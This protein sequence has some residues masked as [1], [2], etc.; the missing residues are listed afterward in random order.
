MIGPARPQGRVRSR[1]SV[2]LAAGFVLLALAPLPSCRTTPTDGFVLNVPASVASRV[3]WYEV[4]VFP[5]PGCTALAPQLAGG[6]PAEGYVQRLA[7]PASDT[8]PPSIADLPRAKYAIG[9]AARASDCSVLATGCTDADLSQTSAV[10]VVLNAVPTP[11]GAC[12]DGATCADAE[13]T[14]EGGDVGA[15]C[16]LTLVGAGPLADPL[17]LLGTVMSAPALAATGNGF[18]IAYREWDPNTGDARITVIPVDDQGGL[19]TPQQTPQVPCLAIQVSDAAALVFSGSSG[20]VAASRAGC[21]SAMG[22]ADSGIDLALVDPNG[23]F[24]SPAFADLGQTP[25]QLSTAHAMAQ[26]GAGTFVAYVQG[27]V[28]SVATLTGTSLGS[29]ASFGDG[30]MADG[31][32]AASD[33][34][35]ALLGRSEPASGSPPSEDGGGEDAAAAADAGTGDDADT[36]SSPEDG[37]TP[38]PSTSTLDLNLVSVEDGGSSFAALPTPAEFPGNWGSVAAL[39]GRV[40]VASDGQTSGAPVAYRAFDLGTAS[41]ALVGAYNPLG[42]GPVLFADIAFHQDHLFVASER[43]GEITLDVFDDATTTPVLLREVS[44]GADARIPSTSNVRDGRVAVLAT[45]TRVIVAWTTQESLQPDDA[46]G[47]FAV[48][49]CTTP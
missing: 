7:F 39:G 17:G 48:F 43:Q 16:S 22:L 46:T 3:V 9:V 30:R 42:T 34:V 20:V 47:G 12:T 33:D 36:P 35:V 13:C 15:G 23:V 1:A 8:S 14:P 38:T 19:G 44:L 2:P 10:T 37:S 25:L 29:P 26:S 5:G 45:D 4:G 27:S 49:A 41:P 11:Q 31:W 21:P 24:S 40:F 32:V 18:L 28:A 6:I